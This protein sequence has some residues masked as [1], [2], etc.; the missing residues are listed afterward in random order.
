MKEGILNPLILVNGMA[1]I[2]VL[3]IIALILQMNVDIIYRNIKI[4]H[5]EGL[6]KTLTSD[7]MSG[8]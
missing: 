2:G 7:G 4:Y 1:N 8:G 6:Q 3:G 5:G